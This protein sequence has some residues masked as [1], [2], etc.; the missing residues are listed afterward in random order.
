M[1]TINN[2]MDN[3]PDLSKLEFGKCVYKYQSDK[4]ENLKLFLNVP[5]RHPPDCPLDLIYHNKTESEIKEIE[6]KFDELIKN[7][8]KK[9]KL[10]SVGIIIDS[11]VIK[12]YD[13]YLE[14]CF[15]N[16]AK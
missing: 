9:V 13:F 12:K 3:Y 5:F 14:L 11:Y 16:K 4:V 7:K 10:A 15:I 6:L 8:N 1:E 2:K